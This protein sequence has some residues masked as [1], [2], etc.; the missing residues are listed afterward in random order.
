MNTKIQQ[1]KSHLLLSYP[2]FGY[3]ITAT[4][5]VEDKN[6]PTMGTDGRVIYYNSSWSDNLTKN[7][8]MFVLAH[9]ISH[10]AFL[11]IARQYSKQ[12]ELWNVAT[13]LVINEL[14]MDEGLEMVAGGL[15]N[16]ELSHGCTAEQVYAKLLKMQKKLPPEPTNHGRWGEN[17]K[18]DEGEWVD[19]IATAAAFAKSIGNL[20]VDIDQL[21]NGYIK[22]KVDP[23]SLLRDFITQ[24]TMTNDFRLFPPN[25]KY[26]IWLPS[27]AKQS[28][29]EG[30]VVLDTSGSMSD[31]EIKVALS[32]IQDIGE[33]FD[34]YS[35][36]LI[37]C[38]MK[39]QSDV[40]VESG[41]EFPRKVKGRGGTSFLPPFKI[42]D[43]TNFLVYL[44]DGEGEFPKVEPD[45]PVIWLL[46]ADVAVPWGRKVVF[47]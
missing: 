4:E 30:V 1:A 21:V 19:R 36:R 29:V 34:E 16:K 6:V 32:W 27:L 24:S 14:L 8:I 12:H 20:S 37:Q 45:Y 35:L 47:R 40:V 17:G 31:D 9:E 5:L 10:M 42:V 11:H 38:D 28:K 18:Q 22:P 41:E 3:L 39:I 44:T 26:D 13:D 2:F 23:Y 46:T 25:K 33:Q 43:N 7:Q 15:Y